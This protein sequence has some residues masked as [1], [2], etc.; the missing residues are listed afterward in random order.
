MPVKMFA[1]LGSE[2]ILG[3]V[4]KNEILVYILLCFFNFGHCKLQFHAQITWSAGLKFTGIFPITNDLVTITGKS[5]NL[6]QYCK[7]K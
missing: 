1:N 5:T 7:C 3:E 4:L 2:K 6:N